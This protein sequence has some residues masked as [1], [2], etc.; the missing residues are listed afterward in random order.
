MWNSTALSTEEAL[1]SWYPAHV[2]TRVVELVRAGTNVSQLF[3][4]S[5]VSEASIHN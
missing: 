1:P 5:D 4:M 2:P 3:E